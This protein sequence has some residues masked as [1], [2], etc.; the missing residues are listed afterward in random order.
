MVDACDMNQFLSILP[1]EE[2]QRLLSLE[3]FDEF[4]ELH[5]KCAHYML[6]CAFN[7]TC[8][9]LSSSLSLPP[10]P[11]PVSCL[12]A[13]MKLELEACRSTS[14]QWKVNRYCLY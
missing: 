13:G 3:M 4:E 8:C 6:L 7:G 1:K 11:T 2:I 14:D 12:E 9:P 5:L 10:S